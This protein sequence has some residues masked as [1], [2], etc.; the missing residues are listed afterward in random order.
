[1]GV[2]NHPNVV[3]LLGYCSEDRERLLVYELMSNRSLED[4]LFTLRTLTLSWKQRLEIMLG[5]AQGL[6]YL[7]EIQVILNLK[8]LLMVLSVTRPKETLYISRSRIFF[9]YRIKQAG[10]NQN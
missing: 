5:A 3:R 4:H 7:H 9:L 10:M 6:A 2:V 1:L 8:N